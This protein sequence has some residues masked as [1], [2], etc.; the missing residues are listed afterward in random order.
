MAFIDSMCFGFGMKKNQNK[1]INPEDL[2]MPHTLPQKIFN[3]Y[4]YVSIYIY[5]CTQYGWRGGRGAG[6]ICNFRTLPLI[7][8]PVN[9]MS[10][11]AFQ[12]MFLRGWHG[13]PSFQVVFF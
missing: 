7:H 10:R 11:V 12:T 4:I 5:I 13:L 1:Q 9:V 6:V 2:N 8:V 3:I